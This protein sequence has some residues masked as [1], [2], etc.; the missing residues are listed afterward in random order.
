[1]LKN[2]K[3]RKVGICTRTDAYGVDHFYDFILHFL[4]QITRPF[5]GDRLENNN[6][7]KNPF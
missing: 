2:K 5:Y 3:N 7:E 1:M 6:E 4:L